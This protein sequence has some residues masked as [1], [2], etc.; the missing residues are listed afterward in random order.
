MYAYAYNIIVA[1]E[2]CL[3]TFG[4]RYQE[5]GIEKSLK[6]ISNNSWMF[7]RGEE[8]VLLQARDG[9]YTLMAMK[10]TLGAIIWRHAEG[11]DNTFAGGEKTP[12]H[13]FEILIFI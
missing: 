11:L 2:N 6:S 13:F 9:K 4:L 1:E 12:L 8:I 5:E 7:F 3:C 10:K